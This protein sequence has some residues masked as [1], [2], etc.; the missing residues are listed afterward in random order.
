M[1]A[2]DL[3]AKQN[4]KLRAI[5]VDDEPLALEHLRHL[6]MSVPELDLV[7]TFVKPREALSWLQSHQESVD[8]VFLDITMPQWDGLKLAETIQHSGMAVDVVFVTAYDQ[9][10]LEAFRVHALDYLL[11]PIEAKALLGVVALY[12]KRRGQ[13][14]TPITPAEH[15]TISTFGGLCIEIDG[16]KLDGWKTKKAEELFALVLHHGRRKVHREQL[17]EILWPDM[18]LKQASN[19]LYTVSYYVRR[20]LRDHGL[21][22]FFV[23]DKE[24]YYVQ[25]DQAETDY[26]VFSRGIQNLH[27][28]STL[29]EMVAVANLYQ[30][31]YFGDQGYSWSESQAVWFENCY[32]ELQLRIADTYEQQ[33]DLDSAIITLKD[34]LRYLPYSEKAYERILPILYQAQNVVELRRYYE[35]Y[36]RMMVE[37]LGLPP[38]D[39][40]IR[41]WRYIQRREI[42]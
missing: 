28:N 13:L 25:L 2:T 38:S 35:Q 31:R 27:G 21:E 1:A 40:V 5:A 34:L 20:F 42:R 7:R 10:A 3:T 6:A 16:K 17:M 22:D 9:Y 41:L 32:L 39:K 37:E 11:K 4:A 14:S 18:E 19:N 29:A 8:L 30:G 26:V 23:R 33:G 12:N 36:E 15:L 24:Q